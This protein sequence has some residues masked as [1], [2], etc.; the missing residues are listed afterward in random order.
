MHRKEVQRLGKL[1]FYVLGVRPDE[2][3]LVPDPSGFLT[4]KEILQALRE[5]PEW[6]FVG[7]GHLTEVFHSPDR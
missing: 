6:S 4:L 2:F 7:R 1:L 5:D 3:G